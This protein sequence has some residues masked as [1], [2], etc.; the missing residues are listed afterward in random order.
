MMS[1]GR[2]ESNSDLLALIGAKRIFH[3][4]NVHHV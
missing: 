1:E 4:L 3:Q 2:N